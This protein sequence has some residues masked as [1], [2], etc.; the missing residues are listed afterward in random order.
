MKTTGGKKL[1]VLTL[2]SFKSFESLWSLE[3]FFSLLSLKLKKCYLEFL[4]TGTPDNL[5][6]PLCHELP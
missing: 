1:N 4:S 5:L 2:M 3:L 6:I